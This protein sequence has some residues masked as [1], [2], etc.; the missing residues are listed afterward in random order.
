MKKTTL[1][2][3]VITATVLAACAPGKTTPPAETAVLASTLTFTP[4]PIATETIAPTSAPKISLPVDR[5][6]APPEVLPITSENI[7]DLEPVAS[8]GEAQLIQVNISDA[9]DRALVV[10]TTGVQVYDLPNLTPKPFLHF[11]L[12]SDGNTTKY[13]FSASGKFLAIIP[14]DQKDQIQI[15][16]LET[17]EKDCTFDLPGDVED[18]GRTITLNFLTGTNLFLFEGAWKGKDDS[19]TQENKMFDLDTCQQ[20]FAMQPNYWSVFLASPDGNRVAYMENEQIVVQNIKDN[21]R[22]TIGDNVNVRG[23]GFTADSHSIIISYSNSTKIYDLASGEIINEFQSNQG[24]DPVFIYPLGNGKRIL[25]AGNENN[26]I[27]DTETNTNFALGPEFITSHR[28][29]FDD[30]NGALVTWQSLWNLNKKN[31]VDLTKYPY[32]RS[33]SA[34]S[35]DASFLAIDSGYV[36]YQTDLLAT[37]TGRIILSLPRERTPVAVDGETF[38]TS[39]DGQ[40]FVHDFASGELLATLQGEYMN[41]KTLAAQQVLLWDAKGN[42]SIL[43]VGEGSIL[44]QAALPVFPMDYGR[45]PDLYYQKNNFPAWE[46]GLGYDPSSWL[47]SSGRNTLVVSP[48]H[49][50]GIQQS[51]DVVSIFSITGDTFFPTQENLVASYSFKGVWLQFKFSVDGKMVVGT[52]HSQLIVWDSQTGKQI[53]GIYGKKYLQGRTT[54]FGFSPDGSKIFISSNVDGSNTLYILDVKTG[55]LLQSQGA[56]NCN[57][58]LPYAFTP[59]GTQIFTITPDC[60]IGLYNLSDWQEVKSF[61]GPYSG[62]ELALALSPDGKLLATGQKQ[63]LEIWDVRSGKLVKSFNDLDTHIEN[64]LGDFS[65]AFSP[66]SKLLAVRYGRWFNIVSTVMLFGVPTAP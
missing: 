16:N 48:D 33:L 61:G 10:Y 63:S 58:N 7:S 5:F 44:Q 11:D 13:N 60:R 66:D 6:T 25:I 41:G 40:I 24:R 29:F 43:D 46:E 3:V 52:T 57:L 22:S 17:Q 9:Q 38:I 18:R 35:Q 62:A 15:W 56:P 19:Q 50:T 1:F 36:P 51:G 53:K 31:R 2:I 12:T 27:W 28:S 64:F 65:L 39:G 47:A 14:R 20:V 32:G 45:M 8:Y 59:D 37:A 55:E 26:R 54:D 49:K 30:R 23:A 4:A 34:L 21:S 42:I